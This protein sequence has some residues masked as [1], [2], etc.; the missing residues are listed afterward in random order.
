MSHNAKKIVY[1][2]NVSG[3]IRLAQG[4]T[5][6]SGNIELFQNGAFKSICDANPDFGTAIVVCRQLGLQT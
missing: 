3:N 4:P 1:V 2:F 6:K 5:T